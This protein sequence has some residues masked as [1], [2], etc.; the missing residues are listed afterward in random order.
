MTFLLAC[1]LAPIASWRALVNIGRST[2]PET[3]ESC[4]ALSRSLL[5]GIVA[6]YTVL[7]VINNW[8]TH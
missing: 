3:S 8:G 2:G 5:W 7:I 1:L 4:D 6:V